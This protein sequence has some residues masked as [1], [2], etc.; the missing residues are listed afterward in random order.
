MVLSVA[1]FNTSA[2]DCLRLRRRCWNEL[3]L[4]PTNFM[5]TH[6]QVA[7]RCAIRSSLHNRYRTSSRLLEL[8]PIEGL[9]A[10]GAAFTSPRFK[11]FLDQKPKDGERAGAIDPLNSKDCLRTKAH[12]CDHRQPAARNGFH[13]VGPQRAAPQPISQIN[14]P[15]TPRFCRV[16]STVM[17]STTAEWVK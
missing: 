11:A 2:Q 16:G 8:F 17:G 6:F 15:P 3:T 9:F 4:G 5:S 7:E 1:R 10:I 14:L 13:G 12:D